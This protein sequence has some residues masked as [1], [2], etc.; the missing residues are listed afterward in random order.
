MAKSDLNH[1]LPK[2]SLPI[3]QVIN[4]SST[5]VFACFH[6]RKRLMA[7][8]A[9]LWKTCDITLR[10]SSSSRG[11][12]LPTRVTFQGSRLNGRMGQFPALHEVLGEVVLTDGTIRSQKKGTYSHQACS[13]TNDVA[14]GSFGGYSNPCHPIRVAL[15]PV[16]IPGLIF[17]IQMDPWRPI[18]GKG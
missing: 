13:P 17:I 18:N 3:A 2:Q 14:S 8:P 15:E 5:C 10:T 11:I 7:V 9:S 4:R 6:Q 1:R 16:A 12:S